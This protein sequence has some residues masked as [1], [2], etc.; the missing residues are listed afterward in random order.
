MTQIA[1]ELGISRD[2]VYA[3]LRRIRKVF[4]DKGLR[5]FLS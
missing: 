2:T 3:D 4:E 5:R 1:K